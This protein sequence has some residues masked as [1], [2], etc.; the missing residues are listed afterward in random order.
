MLCA[1]GAVRPSPSLATTA[2]A[3]SWAAASWPLTGQGKPGVA[4]EGLGQLGQLP[5]GALAVVEELRLEGHLAGDRAARLLDGGGH[6]GHHLA[7]GTGGQDQDDALAGQQAA[8]EGGAAGLGELLVQLEP[9]VQDA[10]LVVVRVDLFLDL[11]LGRVQPA[12]HGRLQ[13]SRPD[14]DAD[15]QGQEHRDDGDEVVPEVDH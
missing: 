9:L 11:L 3:M 12:L 13:G 8:D 7:V 4:G 5:L 15:G 1:C 10:D 14:N 6:A 2:S